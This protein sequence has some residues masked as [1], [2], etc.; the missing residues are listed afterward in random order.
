MKRYNKGDWGFRW[1]FLGILN[2]IG[3]NPYGMQYEDKKIIF[4]LF[5]PIIY[6]KDRI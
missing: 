1:T 5:I 6:W 3:H 4:L 2:C